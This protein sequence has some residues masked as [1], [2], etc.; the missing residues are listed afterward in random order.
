MNTCTM[1][2][3]TMSPCTTNFRAPRPRTMSPK[4]L[5]WIGFTVLSCTWYALDPA[6][7][8]QDWSVAKAAAVEVQQIVQ[9]PAPAAGLR[10]A[11]R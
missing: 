5:L 6:A 2:A 4:Y 3:C 7:H 10:T 8:P 9:G 1:N 11:M